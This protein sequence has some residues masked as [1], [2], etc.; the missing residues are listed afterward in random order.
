MGKIGRIR[1]EQLRSARRLLRELPVKDTRCFREEA[2]AFLEK[3]LKRA[4]RKG[5]TPKELCVLLKKAAI[6]IPEPLIARYQELVEENRKTGFLSLR[7][8]LGRT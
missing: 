3:D 7:E 4:F 8:Y 1:P 5:Y 6:I 2:A